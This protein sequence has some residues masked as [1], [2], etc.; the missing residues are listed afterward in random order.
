MKGKRRIS[1][2][3]GEKY[4]FIDRD[5][6]VNK[7]PAGWTEYGYVTRWEDF[8]FLP[9]VLDAFKKF[10]ESGY[11]AVIITN[12]QC[13]GKGYL[14]ENE[15]DLIM[16]RMKNEVEE[17]GGRIAGI[18]YCPHLK[19][20][21]CACRK[22]DDGLFRMAAE[23][24]GISD[25]SG[26]FF[27]GDTSRDVAAGKKARLKTIVVLSG[28]S[29]REDVAGFGVKPDYVCEGLLEAADRVLEHENNSV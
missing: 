10:A 5:G 21:K 18:F 24:L 11:S 16:S 14:S 17:H 28:K 7:D 19:E 25:F 23:K 9:G 13:V 8:V 6:V 2:R 27:I 1:V 29:S 15:L 12:Q 4:V 22:P 20:E 3:S 26:S